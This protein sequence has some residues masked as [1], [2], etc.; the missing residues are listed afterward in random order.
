MDHFLS[1]D[2]CPNFKWAIAHRVKEQI[3]HLITALAE[4]E[5]RLV[6]AT[7]LALLDHPLR[8]R[9]VLVF[10]KYDH[11]CHEDRTR[12][13]LQLESR[14]A[15]LVDENQHSDVPIRPP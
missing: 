3:S 4:L 5:F 15:G 13:F 14:I 6:G 12:A 10:L 11:H 2:D 9:A 1:D 7:G 8:H